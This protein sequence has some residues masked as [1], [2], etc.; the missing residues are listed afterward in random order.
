MKVTTL[1]TSFHVDLVTEQCSS[2]HCC[3]KLRMM[4]ATNETYPAI[5]VKHLCVL[6]KRL[7]QMEKRMENTSY[8]LLFRCAP[9]VRSPDEIKMDIANHRKMITDI[10]VQL[11]LGSYRK[12][13][14]KPFFSDGLS[15]FIYRPQGKQSW[16]RKTILTI[17][18]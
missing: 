18:K 2:I 5:I 9:C 4:T 1:C 6:K 15:Q 13:I 17:S 8:Q 7:Q 14:L 11:Q 12:P 16:I 3:Y 10:E